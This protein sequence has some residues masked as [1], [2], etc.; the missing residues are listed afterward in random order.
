MMARTERSLWT[1][2]LRPRLRCEEDPPTNVHRAKDSG[3]LRVMQ[4]PLRLFI[5][6][7]IAVMAILAGL[8][9]RGSFSQPVRE[10]QKA[11][12]PMGRRD[13]GSRA[14]VTHGRVPRGL[15]A[16]R[17]RPFVH[18]R[19]RL[20][21]RGLPA[22]RYPV[23]CERSAGE[24]P[25]R[26]REGRPDPVRR[27]IPGAGAQL[28]PRGPRPQPAAA[29]CART[30]RGSGCICRVAAAESAGLLSGILNTTRRGHPRAP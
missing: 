10:E 25:V 19:V 26:L 11:A 1:R 12:A 17:E 22:V 3:S 28:G 27:R 2:A 7:G 14:G 13:P 23:P 6:L 20:H 16:D 30:V 4:T 9:M 18:L 5:V 15:P 21:A 29:H 24:G 8:A